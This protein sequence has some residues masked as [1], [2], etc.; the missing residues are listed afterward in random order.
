MA[1]N[2]VI[3]FAVLKTLK[4]DE[5]R[6]SFGEDAK[7][8]VDALRGILGAGSAPIEEMIVEQLFSKLCME[9]EEKRN[10]T[11]SDYIRE[12]KKRIEKRR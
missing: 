11:F 5:T 2:F 6:I 3:E 12:L 10:Y 7:V 1:A 8:F 4:K 9:Y